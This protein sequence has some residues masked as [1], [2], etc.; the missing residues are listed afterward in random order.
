MIIQKPSQY[1]IPRVEGRL[2]NGSKLIMRIQHP[3]YAREEFCI[4]C[5]QSDRVNKGRSVFPRI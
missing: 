2:Y 5:E 4:D 3:Q 1:I